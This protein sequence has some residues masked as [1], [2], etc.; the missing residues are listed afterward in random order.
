MSSPEYLLKRAAE[1]ERLVSQEQDKIRGA[2]FA[3]LHD[4]WV[5]LGEVGPTLPADELERQVA[6]LD[7]IQARFIGA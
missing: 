6:A 4:M 5:T 3:L 1:C 2:A 7:Q